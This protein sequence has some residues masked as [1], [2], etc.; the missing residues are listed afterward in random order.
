MSR[1]RD[2]HGSFTKAMREAVFRRDHGICS[3]CGC[4]CIAVKALFFADLKD[5]PV[6]EMQDLL[7]ECHM[8]DWPLT[9]QNWWTI[10]HIIPVA[11]GGDRDL[12][13]LITLCTHC[14]RKKHNSSLIGRILKTTRSH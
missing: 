12:S 6:D 7:R 3:E 10:H 13:N 1:R 4:D 2:K 14:H 9:E 8:N 11:D 5:T